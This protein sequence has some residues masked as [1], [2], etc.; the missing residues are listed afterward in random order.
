[1]FTKQVYPRAEWATKGNNIEF[2]QKDFNYNAT[3]FLGGICLG[4]GLVHYRLFDFSVDRFRFIE[5]M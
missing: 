2:G 5:F 3:A 1:M 4:R